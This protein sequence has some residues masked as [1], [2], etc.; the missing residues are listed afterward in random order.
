MQDLPGASLGD[1]GEPDFVR[2]FHGSLFGLRDLLPH[3]G[4]AVA[5]QDPFGLVLV[6]GLLAFCQGCADEF[7][8]FRRFRGQRRPFD[9]FAS[10]DLQMSEE[11]DH[12][13]SRLFGRV[14]DRDIVIHV[15]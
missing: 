13:P 15:E 2:D 9:R 10:A 1:D 8:G 12:P 14:E 3:D 7:A 6:E 4:N 5:G 11:R